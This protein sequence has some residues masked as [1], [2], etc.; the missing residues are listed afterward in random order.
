MFRI[1]CGELDRLFAFIYL[2]GVV[3]EYSVREAH[4]AVDFNESVIVIDCE[5]DFGWV[6]L[7]NFEFV[8]EFMDEIVSDCVCIFFESANFMFL[9]VFCDLL[10]FDDVLVNFY[11]NFLGSLIFFRI[12]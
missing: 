10:E 4:F 1:L 9:C 12:L 5:F 8:I 2:D 6:K 11:W 7:N 3:L